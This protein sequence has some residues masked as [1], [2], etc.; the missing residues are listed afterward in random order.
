MPIQDYNTVRGQVLLCDTMK[1]DC[2]S[3]I[4]FQQSSLKIKD[5]IITNLKHKIELKDTIISH[6]S[7]TIKLLSV[8]PPKDKFKINKSFFVGVLI[9]VVSETFILAEVMLLRK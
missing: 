6:K 5:S 7:E 3:T 2:D 1:R 9:G 8:A 4:A